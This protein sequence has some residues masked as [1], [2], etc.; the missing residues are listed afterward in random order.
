MLHLVSFFFLVGAFGWGS[1]VYDFCVS[2]WR[3][4]KGVTPPNVMLGDHI[5][6][7]ADR[8]KFSQMVAGDAVNVH[9]ESTWSIKGKPYRIIIAPVKEDAMTTTRPDASDSTGEK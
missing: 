6:A 4:W 9:N 8:L 5:I 2:A 3:K 7:A 1:A